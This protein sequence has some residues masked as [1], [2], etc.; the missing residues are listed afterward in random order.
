[1]LGWINWSLKAF[2]LCC[3]ALQSAYTKIAGKQVTRAK[4]YLNHAVIH[5][6]IWLASTIEASDSVHMMHAVKWDAAHMDLTIFCD[7]SLEG[8]GFI[9]LHSKWGS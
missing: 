3:P 9:T 1:M 7:M 5:D 2:P 6:F 8:L 4:I